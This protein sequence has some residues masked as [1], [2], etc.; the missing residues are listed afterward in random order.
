[1]AKF[2]LKIEDTNDGGMSV[3]LYIDEIGCA[4]LNKNTATQNLAILLID[5]MEQMLPERETV[6][7]STS[8]NKC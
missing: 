5:T 2:E 1:M 4:D 7:T 3:D 8:G 6:K